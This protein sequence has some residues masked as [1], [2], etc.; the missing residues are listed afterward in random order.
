MKITPAK[1]TMLMLVSVAG[2]IGMYVVKGLMKAEPKPERPRIVAVP[3]ATAHLAPGTKI[4]DAHVGL[5]P[6][7][8][9]EL[10]GDILRST[11][12]IVGRVV[13]E[14]IEPGKPLHG[15]Q[16][17]E[18]GENVPL[19]VAEGKQAMAVTVKHSSELVDGLIKPGNF[20]DLHFTLDSQNRD[21]IDARISPLGGVSMTL[22]KGVKVLAVNKNF[23]QG[24]VLA[25]GNSVTLE[26]AHEQINI[27]LVTKQRG[28]ISLTFNPSGEGNG[29]IAL[30]NADRVTLWEVLGLKKTVVVQSAP[31]EKPFV[32]D[33]YRGSNQNAYRWDKD[34]NAFRGNRGAAVRNVGGSSIDV[35]PS[36]VFAAPD[37]K[38][39]ADDAKADD[40]KPDPFEEPTVAPQTPKPLPPPPPS[41]DRLEDNS[42]R[43]FP[44]ST[45]RGV[46]STVSRNRFAPRI[47]GQ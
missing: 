5:G 21:A 9:Q 20:V 19:E 43:S 31:P 17:Y 11:R 44:V 13:K 35:D 38:D 6:I 12:V 3:L 10:K 15:T 26:L 4:T 22:L 40:A 47:A 42:L 46:R 7:A 45:S 14:A 37:P 29:G 30:S 1:V 24:P 2:L 18:P 25:T 34:G 32:T 28:T 27:L 23:R 39:R 16:L 36:D 41:D 33:V 8:P